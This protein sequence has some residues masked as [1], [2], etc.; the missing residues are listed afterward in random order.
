MKRILSLLLVV[1]FI[2]SFSACSQKKPA[3]KTELRV[4]T[5][6]SV[7][8]S[9]LLPYL[10]PIFEADTG[11]KLEITSAGTGAAIEKGRTG[12]A[13][14]LL[15]HAKSSE[16]EFISQGF[17]E[18]RIPFMHNYFVIVGPADDP[19]GV[20][21]ASNA[22]E[23]FG[24]IAKTEGVKFV[25]RGDKSGTHTAELKLWAAAAIEPEGEDFYV[26]TGQGMGTSLNIAAE[27]QAYILTDKATYLAHAK[28]EELKLLLEESPDLKNTY[29]LLIISKDKW[30]ETNVAGAE[31]L[32]SWLTS[33]KAKKLIADFG[34]EEYG[35]GLFFIGE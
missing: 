31:A 21:G 29:S 27:Q 34:V 16:E 2:F 17:S 26:S 15:V 28:R 9:G 13:D 1:M 5:T 33:D 32:V 3:A 12:D 7:N 22:V 23:A 8:D 10:Q 14:I 18:K 24:L 19:A 6:T 25:S 11:F 20:K 30:P 35:E 4:S